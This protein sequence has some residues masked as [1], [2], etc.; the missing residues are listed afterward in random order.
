MVLSNWKWNL[1]LIGGD[2]KQKG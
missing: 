2:C 1:E